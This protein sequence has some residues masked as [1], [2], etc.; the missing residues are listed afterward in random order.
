[1]IHPSLS[2][3]SGLSGLAAALNTELG[4]NQWP[5]IQKIISEEG[6]VQ[7]NLAIAPDLEWFRG[8]FPDHPVLPGVVQVHWAVS[9]AI[10]LVV[11]QGVFKQ[12]E[13]LK[14]KSVVLPGMN[15]MLRL[16][17]IDPGKKIR[18]VFSS[19]STGA[20]HSEGRIQ[21]G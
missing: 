8:H 13:N 18:F 1:M 14:F 21:F 16:S 6:V 12:I 9:L 5:I 20:V 10:K 3:P 17:E 11:P 7:L 2:N 4:S 19:E 15:L